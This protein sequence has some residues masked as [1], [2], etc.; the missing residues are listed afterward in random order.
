MD[1]NLT[2]L[3]DS[4]AALGIQG[5]RAFAYHTGRQRFPYQFTGD[6]KDPTF[7]VNWDERWFN[8]IITLCLLAQHRKMQMIW[9]IVDSCN[10][11]DA[12]LN[13]KNKQ[14]R[15]WWR[16][17]WGIRDFYSPKMI[18][19]LRP[20][21]DRFFGILK[22]TGVDYMI[23]TCN[24]LFFPQ[25]PNPFADHRY[26]FHK[27]LVRE[28]EKYGVSRDR[29]VFS[30][31]PAWRPFLNN[32][33]F[34]SPH[35]ITTGSAVENVIYD[36]AGLDPRRVILS[37]DG[38]N[39][40]GDMGPFNYRL[41]TVKDGLDIVKT[42]KTEGCGFEHI[43]LVNQ[44]VGGNTAQPPSSRVAQVWS[45]IIDGLQPTSSPLPVMIHVPLCIQTKLLP[46]YTCPTETAVFELGKEP[47]STC[48][49]DHRTFW[50]KAWHWL[51]GE[52]SWW[53]HKW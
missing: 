9:T 19:R 10:L 14:K 44:D 22:V 32:V 40:S 34:Y 26:M 25:M 49:I 50:K 37:G 29:M 41:M 7:F 21:L 46:N 48:R 16:Q 27:D 11:R 33:K 24:E 6:Y 31:G 39:G 42:M 4:Y 3:F 38:G 8:D 18:E 36:T 12:E 20:F 28:L 1:G 13:E 5:M 17:L 43:E 53:A 23:E 15:E 2:K 51:F 45:V 30:G 47:K 35:G 52:N